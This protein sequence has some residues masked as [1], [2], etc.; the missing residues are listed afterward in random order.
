MALGDD[1]KRIVRNTLDSKW[2]VR[3]GRGVPSTESVALVGGG[4]KLEATFLF[5]DMAESSLLSA[6]LD[7]RVAAKIVKSFLACTSKIVTANN[8]VITSFDGDRIMG[9][10]Y[11]NAKNSDATK[12][13]LKIKYAVD[14]I[15][16]PKMENHFKTIKSAGFEVSHGVGIDTG[17]VLVVRAGQR[18]DNDLVWIGRS[19]NFA[20]SLSSMR[21]APYKSIISQ[22]VFSRL[23]EASKFGGKENELMWEKHRVTWN[24]RNMIVYRSSWRWKV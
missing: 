18:G 20:A 21:Q 23:N 19:P 8:G 24:D 3:D 2:N 9:V 17:N 11:G 7:R 1:L 14:N 6:D 15:I 16:R 12:C 22:D 10:F 13:A 5:A 4:V